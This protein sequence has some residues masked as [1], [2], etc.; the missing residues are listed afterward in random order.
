MRAIWK[1]LTVDD[2]S[3]SG[4]EDLLMIG[5]PESYVKSKDY[6]GAERICPIL[7]DLDDG[8]RLKRALARE[9]A[10]DTPR[11]AEMCRRYLADEE[12]FSEDKLAAAGITERFY[13]GDLE[14]CFNGIRDYINRMR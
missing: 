14:A 7:I 9:M 1:Y 6:F 11:Y 3:F 13:N 10:Q 8:E 4:K 2:G 12:D 5:T